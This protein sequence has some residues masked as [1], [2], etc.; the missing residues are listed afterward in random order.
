MQYKQ[1]SKVSVR[2]L[3]GHDAVGSVYDYETYILRTVNSS[4]REQTQKIYQTYQE[5][6][7]ARLG[8]VP[9]DMQSSQSIKH[10]KYAISYPH[11]WTV[12]M[13]KDALL[14]HLKLF[15]ELDK[16]GLTLKDAIPQNIVFDGACVKFI[17]FFSLV[18]L[19]E[20]SQ[21]AWLKQ[22][23]TT[24]QDYRWVVFNKLDL[25]LEEEV[26]EITNRILEGLDWQGE[27]HSISAFNKMGTQ[28][29]SQK[30]MTF[31]EQLPPEEEEV[32]DSKTVEFKW[33]TY[34]EDAMAADGLDD[35]LDDD[36]W[37]ED[38]YDVEVEYRP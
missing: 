6:N 16:H 33:D 18:F 23:Q 14:L 1:G 7:L 38:D 10:P 27:V 28:E 31:I 26:E 25:V 4:Y 15:I 17:D 12:S 8:I 35:D 36:D 5:N 11:E 32:I 20:L 29:L 9:A 24:E 21:E 22:L 19:N 3:L 34:H 2:Q 13:F 30:V 37:N